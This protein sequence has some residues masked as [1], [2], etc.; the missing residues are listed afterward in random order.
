MSLRFFAVMASPDFFALSIAFEESS[1]QEVMNFCI[2]GIK[3]E[4][5]KK[6]KGA[7]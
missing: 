6:I 1:R 2:E 4:E 7:Q 3:K 5:K